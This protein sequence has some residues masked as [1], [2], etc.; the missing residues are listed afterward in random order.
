METK[1]DDISRIEFD[2]FDYS[3]CMDIFDIFD[4]FEIPFF[5]EKNKKDDITIDYGKISTHSTYPHNSKIELVKK[6][7]IKNKKNI[8]KRMN[9]FK[10]MEHYKNN[11]KSKSTNKNKERSRSRSRYN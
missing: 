11:E 1:T 6:A 10:R 2:I 8:Q 3:K 5:K 4:K 9:K 7:K